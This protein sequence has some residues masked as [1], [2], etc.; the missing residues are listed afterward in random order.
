MKLVFIFVVLLIKCV[1]NIIGAKGISLQE[2]IK[3]EDYQVSL[4]RDVAKRKKRR[5]CG[6]LFT[7]LV[8]F[9]PSRNRDF[10]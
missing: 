9:F 3:I 2:K 10:Y 6:I 8:I 1:Y 7:H 5:G 4:A